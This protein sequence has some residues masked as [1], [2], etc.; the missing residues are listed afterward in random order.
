MLPETRG[1]CQIV[2]LC[3]PYGLEFKCGVVVKSD[4]VLIVDWFYM[5]ESCLLVHTVSANLSEQGLLT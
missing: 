2:E 3:S 5:Q 1:L 4:L